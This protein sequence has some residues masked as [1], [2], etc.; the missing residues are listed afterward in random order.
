MTAKVGKTVTLKTTVVMK[1]KKPY[2]NKLKWASSNKKIATVSDK[3]GQS[4]KVK[5][6]KKAKKGQKVK[7][8]AKSTD[9][10]NKKI[11]FTIKITK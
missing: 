2:N 11:T 5:I 1:G 3:T 7:I 6:S 4:M 8:T 9:G 10:T